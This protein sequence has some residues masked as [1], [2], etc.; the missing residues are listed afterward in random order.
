MCW[1]EFVFRGN[2]TYLKIIG[3]ENMQINV[4]CIQFFNQNN[5]ANDDKTRHK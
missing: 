3:C 4:N 1:I 2:L 5:I